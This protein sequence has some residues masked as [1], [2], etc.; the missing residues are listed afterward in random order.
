MDGLEIHGGLAPAGRQLAAHHFWGELRQ[1]E[2]FGELIQVA[3]GE[4]VEGEHDHR[5]A[6]A[7][8]SGI[9]ER[10]NVNRCATRFAE[11]GPAG[12]SC[13]NIHRVASRCGV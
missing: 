3:L 4:P 7:G 11:S 6:L 10:L 13:G 9:A 1:V 12:T 8:E 2:G 5:D